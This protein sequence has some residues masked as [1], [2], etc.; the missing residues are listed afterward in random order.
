MHRLLQPEPFGRTKPATEPLARLYAGCLGLLIALGPKAAAAASAPASC[1]TPG[2][3]VQLGLS[4]LM[5]IATCLLHLGITTLVTELSHHRPLIA[6][7]APRPRR[8]S[9]AVLL[10]AGLIGLALWVEILIWALLLRGLGLLPNL[11]S[12]LYFSGITFTSVGYGDVMLPNCWQLLSVGLAV[13]GLLLAGWSTALL[14]Y[15]VQR[16]MEWRLQSHTQR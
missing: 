10:G 14:V 7:L 9:L 16:S 15:L 2:L 12:S 5:L 1:T 11:E 13:N 4:G 8:R 6:W 3:G